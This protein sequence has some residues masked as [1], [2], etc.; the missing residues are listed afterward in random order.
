MGVREL[1]LADLIKL[2]RRWWWVLA[3]CPI[4]AAGVAFLVSS[5]MTPIYRAEATLLIEQS[6]VPGVT[7]YNDI[8]AAE[9]LTRTYSRLVTT[10]SVLEE[11]IARLNLPLTPEQLQEQ[12]DVTAVRDTQLVQVAVLDPSPERAA[13]VANTLVQVFIEQQQAQRRAITG[14]SREELQRSIDDVRARIDELSSRIAELEQRPMPA[15]PKCRPRCPACAA[16]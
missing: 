7:Q 10:R 16:S 13:T 5:A 15:A 9:R 4:L 12:I 8:L 2:G 1:T 14:S 6:Q 3:L 11:T